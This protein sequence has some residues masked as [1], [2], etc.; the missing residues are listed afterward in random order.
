M[1]IKKPKKVGMSTWAWS[2]CRALEHQ[3]SK[4]F[5]GFFSLKI[6]LTF[7]SS[8]AF[9]FL[10]L[11]LFFLFCCWVATAG[12]SGTT[13]SQNPAGATMAAAVWPLEVAQGFPLDLDC[14]GVGVFAAIFPAQDMLV[15]VPPQ[16]EA[17]LAEP[18]CLDLT[19][20]AAFSL[21]CLSFSTLAS[22][23]WI[24]AKLFTLPPLWA[25]TVAQFTVLA[26]RLAL[27]SSSIFL[28]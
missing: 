13:G 22:S 21:S 3:S 4:S 15:L 18:E 19:D 17:L 10:F 26:A 12:C 2:P 28:C 9:F 27:S 11:L 20:L 6:C 14:G 7:C 16:M 25:D 23:A 8:S 24:S 5:L 1:S